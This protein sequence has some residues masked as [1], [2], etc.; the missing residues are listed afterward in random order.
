MDTGSTSESEAGVAPTPPSTPPRPTTN[1]NTQAGPTTPLA[2]AHTPL[3]LRTG[4]LLLTPNT[5]ADVQSS[6]VTIVE[7]L[8]RLEDLLSTTEEEL[9][10]ERAKR[11]E[12]ERWFME[13][14]ELR[15]ALQATLESKSIELASL[16]NDLRT[17]IEAHLATQDRLT[18]V[19]NQWASSHLK[20]QQLGGPSA[21]L[22][23]VFH[24][25]WGRGAQN[26]TTARENMEQH[27][28]PPACGQWVPFGSLFGE[29]TPT[30]QPRP[31]I[32]E[33][34]VQS[35]PSEDAAV[36]SKLPT[37]ESA[38]ISIAATE[39]GK[40]SEGQSPG[41]CEP[42]EHASKRC[43]KTNEGNE[44]FTKFHCCLHRVIHDD[45]YLNE[46]SGNIY[47]PSQTEQKTT[48]ETTE[49]KE[50]AAA[51]GQKLSDD[52]QAAYAHAGY[53]NAV[54]KE[55]TRNRVLSP[56]SNQEWVIESTARLQD[57]ADALVSFNP[58]EANLVDLIRLV[59]A[60]LWL[61][62]SVVRVAGGVFI[63]L[64]PCTV[65]SSCRK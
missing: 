18:F 10:N 7:D 35:H 5:D 13:Q 51:K 52:W 65:T 36:Q 1:T 48:S 14:R 61:A 16:Q 62:F 19:E 37:D 53:G 43:G 33:I 21:A 32:P 63:G 56:R 28:S 57:A 3:S 49:N 12:A 55:P 25:R 8:R 34:A 30:S 23:P 40:M 6:L 59:L 9:E 17:E 15:K 2:H 26:L 39:E 64:S 46:V 24:T 22:S 45:E 11:R 44:I 20:L 42:K 27:L 58:R 54:P 50:N 41:Q 60:I 4:Q 29:H 31:P 47:P 38:P